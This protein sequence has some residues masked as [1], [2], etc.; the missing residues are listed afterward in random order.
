MHPF[1]NIATK[2]QLSSADAGDNGS[3]SLPRR[4]LDFVFGY[5]FFISY[6]WSD[7]A[8]YATAL[9]SRLEA[10]GF[11]VFLDR[12]GYASG[13][14]WKTVGAWT[15]LRTGQLILVGSPA[16]LRSDPVL[17][18]VEIF[19]RTRR[20]IVPIDFAG[21]LEWTEPD[22]PLA[23]Y[24]P[25]DILRIKEPAAALH[26][27]PSEETGAS[28]RRTFNLVRQ[29]KKRMR[30]FAIIALLL[31]VLAVAAIAFAIYATVQRKAAVKNEGTS[32]AALSDAA[33]NEGHPVDAVRLALA[34]WPRKG[35]EKRPQMRRVITALIFA[36]SEYHERARLEA[37]DAVRDAAFSPDGKRVITASENKMAQIWDAETGKHLTQLKGHE[38]SVVWSAAFDRD[39]SR[40]ITAS[41]DNTARIWNAETGKLL[42][43]IDA[44]H[45]LRRA[46]FSPDGT[47]IAIASEDKTASIW[48]AGTGKKLYPL[49]H[50]GEVYSAVFSPH[51]ER[52]VTASLDAMGRI[53]DAKTGKLLVKLLVK[54][55]KPGNEFHFATFSPDGTRIATASDDGHVRI[56]NARTGETDGDDLVANDDPVGS[57]VFSPN[58][59]RMVTASNDGKVRIWDLGTRKVLMELKGHDDAVNSVAFSPDGTRVLSA[60][61]DKTARIWDTAGAALVALEHD[62]S[63]NKV[64]FSS[65]GARIVTASRAK[66]ARIWNA[67]TGALLAMIPAS[68]GAFKGDL[69]A[70]TTAAFDQQGERIVTASDY[71]VVIWN[72]RTGEPLITLINERWVLSAAFS[73]DGERIVTASEDDNTA[74]IWD[75]KTREQ[76]LQPLQ[77]PDHVNFASFSPDGGRIVTA[78]SDKIARVWDARTGQLLKELSGH[79][80]RL[81]GAAFSPDGGRIVTASEDGTA[82]VWDA[83]TRKVI[84]V[85]KGH[86][87]TVWSA[88][89]SP[90][91]ARVI[92]GSEDMTVGIW[93]AWTGELLAALRGHDSGVYD[94]VF[95]PDGA[96]IATASGDHTARIWNDV[97][98]GDPFA[99]A[100]AKLRNKTDLKDLER[101]Y[102]L[103]QLK[104]VCG[105]NA[106]DKPDSNNMAD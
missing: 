91:G 89:F 90:N 11:Q 75:A 44:H 51:G 37:G 33:L 2:A 12:A 4:L 53:W 66:T 65:D 101:R 104:P 98:R 20:L 93:D 81:R 1:I 100:C 14:N 58:G 62:D 72:A 77:H 47:R 41:D 88:A 7:G 68:K 5:D 18:E 38:K 67:R 80:G 56:W 21:S 30:V 99:E 35:D 22:S 27:G 95:S 45:P 40:A 106:P 103:T 94:A 83:E 105:S 10:D 69:G 74:R 13:D 31:L 92:T 16:A 34:A 9:A 63:I 102:G 70:M 73:P 36:M 26:S 59:A 57:A 64:A 24:L 42:S 85:L 23:P 84:A 86:H 15:L 97:K 49:A 8:A 61:D 79:D 48:D 32:L 71:G 28:I 17:R 43:T 3:R 60:S 96:Q 76:L 54:P 82:R 55:R 78:C 29:D 50:D 39:G 87:K 46:A 6:S 19:S 52:I 25:A